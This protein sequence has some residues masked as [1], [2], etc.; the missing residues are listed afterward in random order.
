MIPNTPASPSGAGH[1]AREQVCAGAELCS[2]LWVCRPVLGVQGGRRGRR[3]LKGHRKKPAP[4]REG[5][6]SS[7]RQGRFRREKMHKKGP[8]TFSQ[9]YTPC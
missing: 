5:R 8:V 6:G 4:F 1:G 3:R 7:A 9:G 2:V